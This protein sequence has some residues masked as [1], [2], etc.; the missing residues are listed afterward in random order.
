MNN[1]DNKPVFE[2]KNNL[3]VILKCFILI[4]SFIFGC[5]LMISFYS[6]IKNITILKTFFNCF[7]RHL[8]YRCCIVIKLLLM[9]LVLNSNYF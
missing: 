8:K 5:L 1:G 3:N 6:Y 4:I 7:L 9:I 2:I